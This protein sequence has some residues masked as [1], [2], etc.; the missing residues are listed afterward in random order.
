MDH[1]GSEIGYLR[2]GNFRLSEAAA[3]IDS[4]ETRIATIRATIEMRPPT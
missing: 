1:G 2:I 3:V 4:D